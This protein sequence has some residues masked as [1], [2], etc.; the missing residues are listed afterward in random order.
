M[1]IMEVFQLMQNYCKMNMQSSLKQNHISE[2]G[3]LELTIN[4]VVE[5]MPEEKLEWALTQVENSI[6]KLK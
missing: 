5:A 1:D 4:Q 3:K 2:Y 6:K